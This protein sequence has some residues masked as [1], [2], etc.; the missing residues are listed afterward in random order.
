MK[1]TELK[2]IIYYLYTCIMVNI[3]CKIHYIVK[4]GYCLLDDD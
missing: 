4:S 2:V 3:T 1:C